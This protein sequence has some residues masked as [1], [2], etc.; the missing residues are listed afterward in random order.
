MQKIAVCRNSFDGTLMEQDV[1][2]V[3]MGSLGVFSEPQ[4]TLASRLFREKEIGS[5]AWIEAAYPILANQQEHVNR[6]IE[7]EN[8]RE[9]VL[10]SI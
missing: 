10:L 1:G 4:V 8:L 6:L 2:D 3:L 7:S 5:L 9:R